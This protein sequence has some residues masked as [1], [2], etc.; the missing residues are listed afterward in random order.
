MMGLMAGANGKSF[1]F[2]FDPILVLRGK[3]AIRTNFYRH[4]IRLRS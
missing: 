1:F 4:Y 3:F 2:N